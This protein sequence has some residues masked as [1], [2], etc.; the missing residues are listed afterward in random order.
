MIRKIDLMYELFGKAD[1]K[2][3][4]CKHY[5]VLDYHNRTYR[6]CEIYG[7]TQS[8]SS[9]WKASYDACGLFPDKEPKGVDKEI[10]RLGLG[11]EKKQEEQIDGQLNLF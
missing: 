10:I 2:C 5:M 6:K 8:E 7:I 1:G 3:N 11:R 4:D 9:D